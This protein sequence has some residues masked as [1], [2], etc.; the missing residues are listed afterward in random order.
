VLDQLLA[1][2]IAK[3]PDLAK[4]RVLKLRLFLRFVLDAIITRRLECGCGGAV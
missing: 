2:N 3:L 1:A 4:N